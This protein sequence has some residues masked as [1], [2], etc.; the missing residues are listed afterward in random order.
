MAKGI[1]RQRNILD[2]T[3]SSLL[4]RKGKN[5]SLLVV[6]SLVVFMLASAMFLTEA[7]K[8]EAALV[9][10]DAPEMVV[11]RLLMGRYDTIPVE[12][13]KKISA[14]PGVITARPRLW[15]YYYDPVVGANYTL[16]VPRHDPPS[17]GRIAIGNGIVRTRMI[18]REDIVSFRG[19][20]GRARNFTVGQE[21]SPESELVSADLIL[22]AEADFRG[23]FGVPAAQAT[24]IVV[25]VRNRQE[26][27]TIAKKV[28]ALL[29]DTRP[30]IRDEM[31]RTYDSVFDWRGGIVVVLMMMALLAFV[32][33]AWEKASGL[34]ADEKREIGILKAIGWETSDVLAVKAYEGLFVS[35]CSFKLGLLSAYG[36]VFFFSA[37]LF[38]PALKGWSVLYPDFRITPFVDPYQVAVLFFLT[39]VPYTVATLAPS[40]RAAIVDPDS[41]M[42]S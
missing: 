21:L 40:W 23:L 22:M 11:Q 32:I 2:F 36:H 8:R 31:V 6:Y 4:R 42:R 25:T 28:A 30:I 19:Y 29:P 13:V 37:S 10:K 5:L 17:P 35:F 9:L 1:E 20:D 14:I 38:G 15:G 24:D 41:V 16:L 34:S 18:Y 26:L 7:M 39:V 27:L 3:L 12:Y 33:L